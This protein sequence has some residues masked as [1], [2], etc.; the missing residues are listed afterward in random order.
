MPQYETVASIKNPTIAL[1]RYIGRVPQHP[2]VLCAIQHTDLEPWVTIR[3]EGQASTWLAG[4]LPEHMACVYFVGSPLPDWARRLEIW[5][6]RF[7]WSPRGKWLVP[8]DR[9][10]TYP[11][12]NWISVVDR[13]EQSSPAETVHLSVPDAF[14]LLQWKYLGVYRYFLES[15]EHNYLYTTTTGS[16]LRPAM[17]LQQLK[18]LPLAGLYAGT[19]LQ[20]G[21]RSFISGAN[22]LMSR[23]IVERIVGAASELDRG[24]I[25]DLAQGMLLHEWG[26]ESRPLPTINLHS[27]KELRTISDAE[28]AATHHVRIKAPRDRSRIDV[29]IM[30][31]LHD[32]VTGLESGRVC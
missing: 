2:S 25:E 24:R 28:L 6:E 30:Q 16:Y 7:R 20:A 26:V 11:L 13:T 27:A 3:R 21:S 32:R 9:W 10:V 1:H 17:L 18:S 4:P 14:P 29:A 19:P 23:D 8:L 12:R 31:E 22:R 5:H 15:T